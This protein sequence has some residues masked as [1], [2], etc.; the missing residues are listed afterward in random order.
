VTLNSQ[1]LQ[2]GNITSDKIVA[3]CTTYNREAC[4]SMLQDSEK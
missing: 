4:V 1:L 2:T 3:Q